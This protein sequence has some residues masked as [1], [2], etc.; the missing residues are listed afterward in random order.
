MRKP[1]SLLLIAALLAPLLP[2]SISY[3]QSAQGGAASTKPPAGAQP[4][5]ATGSQP[6]TAHDKARAAEAERGLRKTQAVDILKGVVERAGEIQETRGRA[7]VLSGAL[8]LLW[9]HDETYARANFLKSAEALLA[10]FASDQTKGPEHVQIRAAMGVLLKAFARRDPQASGRLLDRFQKLLEEVL[11]DG[12][13]SGLT[14]GERLALA[15]AGLES[16]PAQSAALAAR[17]LEDGVPG[18]FVDY[19]NELERR[20]AAVAASLFR[21]ALSI[22]GGG[23]VYHP[24]QATVLSAYAFREPF[25]SVPVASQSGGDAAQLE[26]GM[27]ANPA[28]PPTREVNPSLAGAYL[29]AAASYLSAR[30]AALEQGGDLNA[31]HVAAC[32]FLVKKLKGYAN[33]LGL[34][35]GPAWEVLD[36]KF[37]LLAERAQLSEQALGGLAASAQRIVADNSVFRFDGG[38]SAFERAEKTKDPAERDELLAHGVRQLADDG[39]YAEAGR[40]IADIR[41]E[42]FREQL[43]DY[44][45]LRAAT[46]SIKK[47]DWDGFNDQV[48]RVADARLR[49]YLLLSAAQR[50]GD[51]KKKEVAS[52]FLQAVMGHLAKLDD[53]DARAGALIT[54]AGIL[55]GVDMSWAMQLLADGVKTINRA[56]RYDGGAYGVTFDVTRYKFYLP[57][58]NSDLGYCFERA[59]R[60]DWPGALAAAQAIN[61][62]QL[63]S[64]A[65]IGACRGVL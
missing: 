54:T 51:A 58:P 61:S 42:K 35:G 22:L 9:K 57:L 1:I 20:D 37:T 6:A 44:V 14:R 7:A 38:A 27:L 62:K 41:N 53:A 56:E 59:A 4:E 40:R 26:F 34:G 31:G 60:H 64:Q 23:S 11:T 16:D 12:S 32:Y 50:A 65:Y 63:Q 17:V 43:T 15:Q 21:K 8:D 29:T 48:N 33:K 45:Q 28:S 49:S 2:E 39:R 25:V 19:L 5:R 52:E 10:Q 46:E 55:S 3:G 47:L 18:S 36:A 24:P 30:A 13:G